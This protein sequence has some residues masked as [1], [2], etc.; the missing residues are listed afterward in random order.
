MF[1]NLLVHKNCVAIY[2]FKL[3]AGGCK[4]GYLED[5][6][7]GIWTSHGRKESLGW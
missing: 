6:N 3:Q 5:K 2:F 7:I 4:I 1:L